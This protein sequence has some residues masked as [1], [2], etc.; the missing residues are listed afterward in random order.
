[1][2]DGRS[3]CDGALFLPQTAPVLKFDETGFV[4]VKQ[5]AAEVDAM[6]AESAARD[7]A[8]TSRASR[9]R[10]GHLANAV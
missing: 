5:M 2:D 7:G 8:R 4:D 10:R 1:M 6:A 9:C 3:L